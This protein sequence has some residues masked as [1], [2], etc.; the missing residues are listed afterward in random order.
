MSIILQEINESL[1]KRLL[2]K[3]SSSRKT[4]EENDLYLNEEHKLLCFYYNKYMELK[5]KLETKNKYKILRYMKNILINDEL[6][7]LLVNEFENNIKYELLE[8]SY[9]IKWNEYNKKFIN[10]LNYIFNYDYINIFL[11]EQDVFLKSLNTR[12]LYNLKYYTYHGD[13]YINSF[14][15]EKFKIDLIKDYSGNLVSNENDLCYFFYQLKD[16]FKLNKYNDEIVNTDNNEIFISF[17]KK[18]CLNFDMK[19]YN[20]IL[21]KYLLEMNEIFKK[22]PKTTQKLILYRGISNDYITSKLKKDFYKNSQFTSTSLF[23]ENAIDYATNKTDKLILKI[24]VNIGMPLIFVE[25]ITLAEK[26]FEVIIP[27]NAIFF[28]KNKFKQVPF[29]KNKNNI[30]PDED[31]LPINIME[32]LYIY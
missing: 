25:G 11:Q 31:I 2:N 1:K 17:I 12:E 14:I 18:E 8:Y 5:A 19:I 16:Y 24:N 10:K 32:L 13:I 30:C 23:I 27:I 7:T 3:L 9:K 28:I 29:Y 4:I 26:D 21:N 6:N 20:Y 15:Q 22:A